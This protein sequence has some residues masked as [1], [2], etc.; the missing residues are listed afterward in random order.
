MTEHQNC[1]AATTDD[2]TMRDDPMFNR[3]VQHVVDLLSKTIG[4]EGWVAGDGSEDY[5]CDLEQTLLNILAAKGLYD[6]DEGEFATLARSSAETTNVSPVEIER[7]DAMN[8]GLNEE[9]FRKAWLAFQNT[10]IDLVA[11]SDDETC[12]CLSNAIR[13]FVR[14]A[15]NAKEPQTNEYLR[16]YA[17]GL[18]DGKVGSCAA[19]ALDEEESY[20]HSLIPDTGSITSSDIEGAFHRL[21][22][23]MSAQ[24]QKAPAAT[25]HGARCSSYPNCNGGCGLGCAHDIEHS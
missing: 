12:K 3:G 8:A 18:H 20:L 10:P 16:G 5:D 15:H 19:A 7:A 6:K 25:F 4:A 1:S 9:A 21:R 17:I 14:A 22:E 24:P 2:N 11:D 13:T 23:R